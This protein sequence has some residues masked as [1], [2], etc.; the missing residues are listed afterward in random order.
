MYFEKNV[1]NNITYSIDMLRLTTEITFF[2]YSEL[3]FRFK[4]VY[5][6]YIKKFYQSCKFADYQYNFVIEVEEGSSFWFGFLHNS[7]KRSSTCDNVNYRFTIEFNP[8]KLKFN[9]LLL[10]VLYS[11]GDWKMRSFDVACDLSVNILDILGFEKGRKREIKMISSGFD[12]KTIYIGKLDNRVKIYNKKIE[13]NLDIKG[14]LTRVEISKKLEDF[15]VKR[16]WAYHF[17][18]VFPDLFLNEYLYSFKDYEDKTLLAVLYAVQNDFPFDNLSRRYKEKIRELFCSG[19][20]KILFDCK[21]VDDV[22]RKVIY[23]YFV[24]ANSKQHFL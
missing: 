16:I 13:S 4:T 10:I 20:Q 5:S 2:Q 24:Q 17:D 3:E 7:E 1:K 12:N 19:G 8:N 6:D 14:D 9:K 23:S 21:C 15:P 11:F 18:N 22:L